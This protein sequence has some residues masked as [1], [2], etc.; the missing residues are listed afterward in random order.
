ME[1]TRSN[2]VGCAI[3]EYAIDAETRRCR[4]SLTERLTISM[5]DDKELGVTVIRESGRGIIDAMDYAV[6]T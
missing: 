4:P 5:N 2:R 1:V 6:L 3:S